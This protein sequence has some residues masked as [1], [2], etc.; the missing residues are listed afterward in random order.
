MNTT[1]KNYY[2]WSLHSNGGRQQR[3]KIYGVLYMALQKKTATKIESA[4]VESNLKSRNRCHL[5]SPLLK[6]RGWAMWVSKGKTVLG[7]AQQVCGAAVWTR[8]KAEWAK[9]R[10]VRKKSGK[11]RRGPCGPSMEFYFCSEWDEKSLKGFVQ[12]DDPKWHIFKDSQ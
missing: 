11:H 4:G 8:Q 2:Q 10:G 12:R 5:S 3:R 6:V 9:G 1:D 7:G